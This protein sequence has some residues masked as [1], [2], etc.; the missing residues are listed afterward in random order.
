M[1]ERHRDI[2]WSSE[3]ARQRVEEEEERRCSG[4]W[5]L[6]VPGM[7]WWGRSG[8]LNGGAAEPSSLRLPPRRG[9]DSEKHPQLVLVKD[10]LLVVVLP[11]I[12]MIYI[13]MMLMPIVCNVT[14][15]DSFAKNRYC[16]Y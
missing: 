4:L 14:G 1:L 2:H 13:V 10:V 9:E 3:G 15:V 12:A 11:V 7:A 8:R 6:A 16:R 5:V